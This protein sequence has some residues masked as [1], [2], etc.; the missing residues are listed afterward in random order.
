V[1]VSVFKLLTISA[2]VNTFVTSLTLRMNDYSLCFTM[3]SINTIGGIAI[4]KVC[5]CFY[6]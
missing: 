2:V 1:S 5:F 4:F 6:W 3:H